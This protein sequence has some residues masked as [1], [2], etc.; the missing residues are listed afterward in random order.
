MSVLHIFVYVKLLLSNHQSVSPL[1]PIFSARLNK[2]FLRKA[3]GKINKAIE[4]IIF[5]FGILVLE[6]FKK[7]CVF[8][9]KTVFS[10]CYSIAT[11]GSHKFYVSISVDVN[12][13]DEYR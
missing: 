10:F 11:M 12:D 3:V 1:N 7:E 8:L 6:L 9:R 13:A 4:Q 5:E 2:I